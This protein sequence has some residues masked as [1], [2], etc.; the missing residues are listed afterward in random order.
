MLDRFIFFIFCRRHEARVPSVS[1]T[2]ICSFL[3]NC[4]IFIVASYTNASGEQGTTYCARVHSCRWVN[5]N[6]LQL[7]GLRVPQLQAWCSLCAV[8]CRNECMATALR[9]RSIVRL[10][11]IVLMRLRT[12]RLT[13]S[14]KH[15]RVIVFTHRFI[16]FGNGVVIKGPA[17]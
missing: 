6:K 14:A 7:L 11:D 13:L 2:A 12:P 1:E 17:V 9:F 8:V 15:Q 10:K 5:E 4:V 16:I 3:L